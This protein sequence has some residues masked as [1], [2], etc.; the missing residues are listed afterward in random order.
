MALASFSEA[1]FP[2]R[3]AFGSSGGPERRTDIVRLST[4]FETRNQRFARSVRHYDAGSGLKSLADLSAVLEFFEAMRGKL[5]GF[6]FRDPLDHT[7][8]PLGASVTALDQEIGVGDGATTRFALCKAYGTADS[9]YSRPIEKP[10]DGSVLIA[11]GGVAMATGFTV[12]ATSGIVSFA[13][14]P[15][16]G[17]PITAGFEYDVPVR[18]DIDQ[19]TI[20]VT[21]FQ[22]GD[23]PNIPLIEVRP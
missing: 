5:I 10:V 19:L 16:T 18:F 11:Q 8:A 2:L 15:A 4:G 7:S 1:R 20:N 9:A 14:P 17:T 23:I 12:D 21:A 6:R 13:A 3:V 22:A